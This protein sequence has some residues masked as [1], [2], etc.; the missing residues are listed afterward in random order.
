MDRYKYM[1][2]PLALIPQEIIDLYDLNKLVHTVTSTSKFG[3]AYTAF[4]KL[5]S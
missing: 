5:A 4:P 2:M 3:V 1:K